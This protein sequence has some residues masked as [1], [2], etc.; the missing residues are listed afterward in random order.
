MPLSTPPPANARILAV[1]DDAAIRE[2]LE[3]TLSLEGHKPIL[4]VDGERALAILERERVDLVLLDVMLPGRNGFEVLR[5][6]RARGIDVPVIMLTARIDEADKVLGLE[7]GADDYVT[8]PFSLGEL[9]ARI[10][11]AL[12]RANGR[13]QV[14]QQVMAFA[15]VELDRAAHRVRK[16]GVDVAMTARE[17]SLLTYLLDRP[18]RV[19][20]RDTLLQHVWSTEHATLRT[21]DNFVMRLRAKLEPIPDAPR[22]FVTVRGIGYRFS[23]QGNGDPGGE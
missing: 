11:A 23:P 15:D 8:K 6:M 2:G 5:T 9:R 16:A 13:Q 19:L 22:F 4:A 18:D 21:V 3:I 7:L 20:T 12:R 17:F 1:E 10:R 14:P